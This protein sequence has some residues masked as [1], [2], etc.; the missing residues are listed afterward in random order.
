MLLFHE[1]HIHMHTVT[2]NSRCRQQA[3]RSFPEHVPF[4]MFP[5]W[6]VHAKTVIIPREIFRGSFHIGAV[7]VCG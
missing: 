4:N 3:R 6:A 2:G 5:F 7:D 1:L